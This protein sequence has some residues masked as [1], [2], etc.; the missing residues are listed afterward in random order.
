EEVMVVWD[1]V[2]E[3]AQYAGNKQTTITLQSGSKPSKRIKELHGVVMAQIE[4]PAE[5]LV[6]VDDVLTRKDFVARGASD[7]AVRVLDIAKEE[8]GQYKVRVAVTAPKREDAQA[9]AFGGRVVRINRGARERA[10]ILLTAPDLEQRGLALYDAKG[11]PIPFV[12][13][14]AAQ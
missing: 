1:G 12:T 3:M 2:S 11:D 8:N 13:G 14:Q 6:V 7:S 5:P 4:A 9:V 10:K